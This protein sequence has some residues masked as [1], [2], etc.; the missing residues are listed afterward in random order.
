MKTHLPTVKKRIGFIEVVLT[1]VAANL[2]LG[3]WQTRKIKIILIITT[4]GEKF[5]FSFT[6]WTL[7]FTQWR[8]KICQRIRYTV[9]IYNELYY[10]FTLRWS[11]L[12]LF[13]HFENVILEVQF[14]KWISFY[15]QKILRDPKKFF[16]FT[17]ILP[18]HQR[19]LNKKRIPVRN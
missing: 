9:H 13:S 7:W 1:A 6:T 11:D 8:K 18:L 17:K 3:A 10:W 2:Q 12:V 15:F 19:T 16:L 14:Q 5:Q 4:L